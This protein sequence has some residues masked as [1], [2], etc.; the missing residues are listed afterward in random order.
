M[1][2]KLIALTQPI[3]EFG[4]PMSAEELITYCARVS[5]PMNQLNFD[6]SERLLQYLCR[7]GHWSPFEMVQAVIEIKT[8]RDIARQILRHRSFSFQEFSQRYTQVQEKPIFREAR[9]Q[10]QKNRQQSLPNEDDS[11]DKWWESQQQL[12]ANA[13]QDIYGQAIE[14]GIAKEVARVVLPEGT[15]PTCLYMSGSLRSWIHYLQLRTKSETQKE[16]REIAV[17]CRELLEKQFP[18]LGAILYE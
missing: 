16:H 8:T 15:T 3:A 9:L 2:V 18:S 17:A 1:Q 14:R 10:D 12:I 4:S 13:A 7:H 5:N 6:T 11:L